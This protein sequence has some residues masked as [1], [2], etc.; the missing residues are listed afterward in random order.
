MLAE[1]VAG[2]LLLLNRLNSPSS[3][4]VFKSSHVKTCWQR[5][6]AG[7]VIREYEF[8]QMSTQQQQIRTLDNSYISLSSFVV[9]S[10]LRDRVQTP[11]QKKTVNP[12]WPP[13]DATFDFP[14]YLS[15]ADKLGVVE[16]V[17]WDKDTFKKDY[18]GEVSI[19]LDEWFKDDNPFAFDDPNNKV[20][21]PSFNNHHRS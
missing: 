7:S 21:F 3:F 15:L 9:V 8:R 17:I 11:V 19:P 16:L 6:G 13:K 20:G 18:L 2:M 10:V 1:G 4:S 5:I 14:L 12:V